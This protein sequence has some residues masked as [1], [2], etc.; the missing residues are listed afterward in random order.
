MGSLN[1]MSSRTT[2]KGSGNNYHPPQ[3]LLPKVFS[4]SSHLTAG[5]VPKSASGAVQAVSVNGHGMKQGSK[6]RGSAAKGARSG[7]SQ[8]AVSNTV[9]GGRQA[10]STSGQGATA[11]FGAAA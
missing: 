9:H 11:G 10:Q 6:K 2:G 1:K 4:G 3:I 8:E 5:T 7:A